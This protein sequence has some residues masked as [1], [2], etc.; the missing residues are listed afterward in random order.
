MFIF[1]SALIVSISKSQLRYTGF[2]SAVS[3]VF[4]L[5][6]SLDGEAVS[7]HSRGENSEK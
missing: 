7:V 5:F 4:F 6:V 1:L 3:A 2:I